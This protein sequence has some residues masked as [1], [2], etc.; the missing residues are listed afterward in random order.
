MGSEDFRCYRRAVHDSGNNTPQLDYH[1]KLNTV[2]SEGMNGL[3]YDLVCTEM[4]CS[5]HGVAS[6]GGMGKKFLVF[7]PSQTVTGAA[8]TY[9]VTAKLGLMHRCYWMFGMVRVSMAMSNLT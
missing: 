3:I 2:D 8:M 1:Q 7:S 4:V 6:A 5:L 9:S